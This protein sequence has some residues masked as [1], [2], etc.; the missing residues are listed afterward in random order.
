MSVR[1]K[2][3]GHPASVG[4]TYGQHLVTATGFSATLFRGAIC[5]AIH[6]LLPFAFE[7]TGSEI[8]GELHDRMVTHRSRHSAGEGTVLVLRA[9][10]SS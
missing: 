7:K 10:E 3:T 4:E 6:A 9:A 8:I 2:F 5:C 1:R